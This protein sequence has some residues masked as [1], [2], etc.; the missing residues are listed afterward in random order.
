MDMISKWIVLNLMDHVY[1]VDLWEF[2]SGI[3]SPAVGFDGRGSLLRRAEFVGSCL[4]K[5]YSGHS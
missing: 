5:S 4:L 2:D 1:A 3:N